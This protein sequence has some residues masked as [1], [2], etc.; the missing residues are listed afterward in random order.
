MKKKVFFSLLA[1]TLI[2]LFTLN[3]CG[4]SATTTTPAQTT[5]TT[6]VGPA[7]ATIRLGQAI[8]LSGPYT[9]GAAVTQIAPTDMWIK[10][11]ND[12]GG[13]YVK[14]WDKKIPLELIRYDDKGETGT[15]VK[16][17]EKLIL[18]DKVDLLL[19][20]YSTGLW[21]ATAP[22]FNSYKYPVVA[23]TV[24]SLQL[25]AMWQDIPYEFVILN[26]PQEKAAAMV[27]LAKELGIKSLVAAHHQDL[28]GIE[29]A[30]G[31]VPA[32]AGAGVDVL[33]YKSYPLGAKDLSPLL[34]EMKAANPDGAFFFGYPDELFLITKQ[35]AEVGFN[36][37]LFYFTI[38]TAFSPYR[39]MFGANLVEGV[40]GAGAWNPDVPYAGAKEFWARMVAFAGAGNTD[41]Y[42]NA[43]C[44]AANQ[45]LQQAIEKAGTL[46]REAI[47][48][49]MATETFPT[50]LGPV[51]FV[52]QF[53]IQS[54]GEVGQWQ[55]GE[56]EIVAGK[57]KRTAQPV[58]PKPPW[59][60][61]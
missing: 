12:A 39:E 22:V 4:E 44:Y 56:F 46:D 40:M 34:K 17:V 48:K 50:V 51:K 21:F 47:R 43:F 42:G 31:V 61:Q 23:P 1:I 57:D 58:Y 27:D 15:C 9:I 24:D 55:K 60:A 38:G 53:N 28:H 33:L 18:E 5:T 49:A 54:P 19:G 6:S 3:A 11:V 25:R 45:V 41:W 10:E 8:S 26:Q 13:L 37:K 52:N 14:Q 29:F 30:G 2:A 16:L 35:S 20:P 36:P 32:L 59:P 7:P